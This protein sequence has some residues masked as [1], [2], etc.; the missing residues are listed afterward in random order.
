MGGDGFEFGIEDRLSSFYLFF[1]VTLGKFWDLKP[2]KKR[3]ERF[4]SLPFRSIGDDGP[5][6]SHYVVRGKCHSAAKPT[7]P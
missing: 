6:L 3:D 2:V 4:L 7:S 1:S 5:H